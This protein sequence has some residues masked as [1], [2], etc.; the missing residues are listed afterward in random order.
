MVFLIEK[1]TDK[2]L[3]A[4]KQSEGIW[5]KT[6]LCDILSNTYAVLDIYDED[7]AKSVDGMSLKFGISHSCGSVSLEI[8]EIHVS[9][10]CTEHVSSIENYKLAKRIIEAKYGKGKKSGRIIR[11]YSATGDLS[12]KT[13]IAVCDGSV[14]T[15]YHDVS[16]HRLPWYN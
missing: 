1:P 2:L 6:V 11:T 3:D 4:L 8:S 14:K 9:A 12:N 15:T 5:V 13:I 7:C 16:D 10:V